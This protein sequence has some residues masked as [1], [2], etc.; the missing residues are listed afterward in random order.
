[1][2]KRTAAVVGATGLVGQELIKELCMRKEYEEIIV[3]T[4]RPIKQEHPKLTVKI[5]DFNY[6]ESAHLGFVDDVYCCLGT[7]KKK[8]KSKEAFRQVDLDYPL[9]LA[10]IAKR[11][12]VQQFLVISALGADSSSVFLYNRIKGLM[13]EHLK[14]IDLPRLQIFR[15]SLLLGDRKEF[16]LGETIGT[17][18]MG[19]LGWVLIG[20]LSSYRA[21]RAEQVALAMVE[22]AL[23]PSN[24]KVDIYNSAVI[25]NTA[26][27]NY[28]MSNN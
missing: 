27:T 14:E 12:N 20:R 25:E 11:N 9:Q 23:T 24:D 13:E 15:P 22:K 19:L 16:R 21:V 6:L 26:R 4:R 2:K 1:M 3:I 7:T 5:I 8:A 28:A 18:V 17:K 10:L